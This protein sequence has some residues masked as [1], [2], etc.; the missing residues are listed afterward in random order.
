MV[1][2]IPQGAYRK[3]I[4]GF[5]AAADTTGLET[6][7]PAAQYGIIHC[8]ITIVFGMCKYKGR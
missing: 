3:V 2:K 4:C 6:S 1:E 7:I 5:P 8:Q